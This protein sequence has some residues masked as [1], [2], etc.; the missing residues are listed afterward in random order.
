MNVNNILQTITIQGYELTIYGTNEKP[1]FVAADVATMIG[2]SD[3]HIGQMISKID[4]DDKLTAIVER[5]GRQRREMLFLTEY[6]FYEVL[7]QSRKPIARKFKSAVKN[8]LH[9]IRITNPEILKE[10]LCNVDPLVDDWE[11]E[12]VRR[13]AYDEPEI[14][15]NEYLIEYKGYTKEMLD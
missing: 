7:M 2:Y 8:I 6:G 13:E 3:D 5:G 10:W 15:F 9:D 1:L 12:C 14:E 11:R 4:M